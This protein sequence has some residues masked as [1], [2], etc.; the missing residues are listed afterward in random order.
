MHTYPLSLMPL[1]QFRISDSLGSVYPSLFM[2][3]LDPSV[4]PFGNLEFPSPRRLNL[5]T[6]PMTIAALTSPGK[7]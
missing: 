4:T 5:S 1:N 3:I 6:S 2:S 7:A